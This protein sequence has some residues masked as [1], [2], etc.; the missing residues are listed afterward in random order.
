MKI[1]KVNLRKI[2]H[3]RKR[4]RLSLNKMSELLG[5]ESQNGYYYLES[6]RNK[7]SAETLAKVSDIFKVQIDE[8]FFEE[9]IAEMA[10]GKTHSA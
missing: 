5:Y 6:G 9:E 3:L 4:E 1:K 7:F 2:K 8:L 10:K